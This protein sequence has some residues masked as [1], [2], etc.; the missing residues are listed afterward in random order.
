MN[1]VAVSRTSIIIGVLAIIFIAIWVFAF[2]VI[3]IINREADLRTAIVAK[4]RDNQS[5][6]DNMWKT[7]KQ[8]AAVNDR[9]AKLIR[10]TIVSYAGSRDSS[11]GALFKAVH[12]AVPNVDAKT[13]VNLQNTI[14]AS[15]QNW[16]MRQKELMDLSREHNRLLTRFPSNVIC[17][18][19]GRHEIQVIIV[20]SSRTDASFATGK[21]DDTGL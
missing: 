10:D 3:S 15:R 13:M 2:G 6:Y 7:I 16:T 8:T 21:D 14:T 11:G 5:E 1:K 9:E 12:E 4:Q 19:F 18:M 20:T 17:S